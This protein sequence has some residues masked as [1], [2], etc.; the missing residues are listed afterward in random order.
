MVFKVD[1]IG[2][3][4]SNPSQ[5]LDVNGGCKFTG[6]NI[7]LD[8]HNDQRVISTADN[9]YRQGYHFQ[10]DT[11]IM[12][13][14]STT[15]EG[16]SGGAIAF[17]TRVGAGSSDTDYGTER[18]RIDSSGNVGIGT[19]SPACRLD[20][21]G[22]D[23]MIR[24]NTPSINFSEGTSAMDGSFRIR[25]DG[26]NVS[27]ND[28]FLAVQTGSNFAVTSLHMT[29]DGNVGIGTTSPDEKLEVRGDVKFSY[30]NSEAMHIDS[31]GTIRRQWYDSSSNSNQGSGFHFTASAIWPTNNAGTYNN[32][33]ITFGH[34]DYR[35]CMVYTKDVNAEGGIIYCNPKTTTVNSPT[36]TGI[37]VKNTE[38]GD[39]TITLR[40]KDS[41]AGDPF[42]SF[43]VTQDYGWSMGIDNSDDN[44]FKLARKWHDLSD[45]TALTVSTS[46]EFGIGTTTPTSPLHIIGSDTDAD[47]TYSTVVIDHNCSG[48]G[49]NTGDTYHSALFI[50]MDS[51]ATGGD[52]IHE[53]RMY[54]I[55]CDTRH[56][57]DS[58]ICYGVY[59][60]TKSDHT[61]GTCT[62]LRAMDA[63]A[64]ASAAGTNTNMY[65]VHSK[66]LK[67]SGSTGTTAKMFGVRGEVEVDAGTCTNAYAFQSHIDRDGGTITTGYLYYGSYSGTVNTKWGLY[68]TG[69]T[70]NYFSGDVGV[71][72]TSP[73]YKLDVHGSANVG[74]LTATTISGPLTGNASTASKLASNVLIGD[75]SFDGSGPIDL[76][77]VN[78]LGTQNTTGRAET[79]NTAA[80]ANTVGGL[81]IGSFL[82]VDQHTTCTHQ[83]TVSGYVN[84][85]LND[86][87]YFIA[88]TQ[89]HANYSL[90]EDE[91]YWYWTG[92][93]ATY[94][95][96]GQGL[97]ATS[98]ER[99]KTDI[100][101]LDTGVALSKLEKIRPVSYKLK[102][103]GEYMFGFIGQEIEKELPNVV[104]KNTGYITDFNIMGVFSNKQSIKYQ[105]KDEEKDVFVYTLTL[106]V[107]IPS[108]FDVNLSTYIETA[109]VSEGI[110]AE[111]FYDPEYCGKPEI[112][113]TVMKLL[114]EK[115][116]VREGVSYKIIGTLVNDFRSLDYN[117]IF[118]VTT[119]ALK[120]VNEQL[121]AEKIKT[122]D[123]TARVEDLE[124]MVSIIKLNM[125]W[126]D[127]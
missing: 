30:S 114:S 61:G 44:K 96:R 99:V 107:P 86:Q 115:D 73:A 103:A 59:S 34:T 6:P 66:C 92:I 65:G 71:G 54:G 78:S 10:A 87:P 85:S 81:G 23:V 18:M 120:E 52:T 58:D 51:T 110:T 35:W 49:T 8:W 55:R 118:T 2:I 76:P 101:T 16:D 25:Y 90:S 24:G 122:A 80:N 117:E 13:L 84:E 89:G 21:A 102:N 70:K 105:G 26:A 98:D 67:D 50:D 14:F 48:G 75:V 79:S 127:A 108:T 121:K 27:N 123:L 20:I 82:R 93:K 29:Y 7:Y 38:S 113:G 112:G 9:N 31:A 74:T 100:Q 11:R 68:L 119:A 33:D 91:T 77:G 95:I 12:R 116:N 57:G 17:S 19:S 37:D 3:G 62:E 104:N 45:S 88:N 56:S 41:N 1:R 106:D 36:S 43:D 72:T 64:I 46:G 39:A 4:V 15:G 126:P 109:C 53:H 42:I 69:E 32:G 94:W 5:N 124:A 40:V 111:F 63:Y 28:N 125:T 60:Y 83:L 22:E 97:L 47:S